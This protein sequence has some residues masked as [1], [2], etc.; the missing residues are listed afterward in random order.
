MIKL[1]QKEFDVCE[2]AYVKISW[3]IA[4]ILTPSP[5]RKANASIQCPVK[6][7]THKVTQTVTLP[8]EIPPGMCRY[9]IAS[10]YR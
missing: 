9:A 8:K 5:R 7:G 3:C 2:E 10:E 1:L 6:E 4:T